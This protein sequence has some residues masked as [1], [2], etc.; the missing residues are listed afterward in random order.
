MSEDAVRASLPKL[1]KKREVEGRLAKL[2]GWKH[3]G[4]FITKTFHFVGFLDGIEFIN[5]VAAIAEGQEH[6]PDI[7][8]RY[9]EVNLS[10]QTHSAGGVTLWDLQLASAIDRLEVKGLSRKK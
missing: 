5:K 7:R 3:E 4:A 1:L 10:L 8:V 2:D 6:H 9:T